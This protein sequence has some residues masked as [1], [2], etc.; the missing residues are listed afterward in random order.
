MVLQAH[1]IER[2]RKPQSPRLPRE[3][4]EMLDIAPQRVH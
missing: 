3:R 4:G 2:A 1:L